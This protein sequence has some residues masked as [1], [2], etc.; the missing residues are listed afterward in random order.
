MELMT[1][2]ILVHTIMLTKAID[3][4]KGFFLTG[5]GDLF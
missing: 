5:N 2:R 3:Q 4:L 1:M